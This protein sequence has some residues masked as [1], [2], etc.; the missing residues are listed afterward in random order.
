M[1]VTV[2]TTENHNLEFQVMDEQ[3]SGNLMFIWHI[4]A[5]WAIFLHIPAAVCALVFKQFLN[6]KDNMFHPDHTTQLKKA[7]IDSRLVGAYARKYNPTKNK[8]SVRRFTF[9]HRNV[10][11]I[12]SCARR[13]QDLNRHVSRVIDLLKIDDPTELVLTSSLSSTK[14]QRLESIKS[15]HLIEGDL[16]DEVEEAYLADCPNKGHKEAK[17]KA[18][19]EDIE[20]NDLELA[21]AVMS[22]KWY[23]CQTK[24]KKVK[25]KGGKEQKRAGEY[26]LQ[27]VKGTYGYPLL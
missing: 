13:S 22:G 8:T 7:S 5:H 20:Y 1:V 4:F 17:Y 16:L 26:K 6:L 24:A 15:G 10:A 11:C 14:N 25:G 18:S 9:F 2:L 21:K 19:K 3:I 27:T 23:T 12:P